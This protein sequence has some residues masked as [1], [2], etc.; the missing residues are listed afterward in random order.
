VNF[1]QTPHRWWDCV[2]VKVTGK[3]M[4][5]HREIRSTAARMELFP[6]PQM[7]ISS[8]FHPPTVFTN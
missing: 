4:A 3:L 2:G 1:F 6:Q 5:R 8:Y 7:E